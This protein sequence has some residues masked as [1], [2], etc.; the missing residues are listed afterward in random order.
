V[1]ILGACSLGGAGHLNPLLPLLAAARRRDD[2]TL[3]VGPADLGR[4]A[5]EAGHAFHEGG[6]PD[7]EQVAPLRELLPVAAPEEASRIGNRELFGRLATS[8]LLPAMSEAFRTFAPQLV[9]RDPCEYS[10]AVIASS[11]G[12]LA[13][14]VAISLAQL[15]EASIRQATPALEEHLPGLAESLSSAPYLSRFPASLDPSPFPDTI[16]Y[17]EVAE[18]TAPSPLADLWHADAPSALVYLS[19]GTV[20]GHMSIAE[21]VYRAALAALSVLEARL[22]VTVGR[23]F[24]PSRLAP[25][26]ANV[27]LARWA[28]PAQVL[29]EADLV[30]CHGGSGTAFGALACGVP[31]VTVPLFADQ[32][33]N[34]RRIAAAGAGKTVDSGGPQEGRRLPIGEDDVPPIRRAAE[35]VLGEA[36]YKEGAR[37]IAGE[38]GDYP[39]AEDVLAMLAARLG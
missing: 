35:E 36:S 6:Q 16:R 2:S 11:K 8:A 31:V 3:V 1:R 5:R 9:L 38:L 12:V 25:V 4:A 33:E 22:L 29:A 24:D 14:Q 18:K 30:V 21:G 34:G 19:F 32:F 39:P 37:L 7:E 23:H 28:D 13:A 10:S 15:E 17:R 27:R 26:P 20:L